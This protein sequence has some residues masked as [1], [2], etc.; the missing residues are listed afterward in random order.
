MG[1]TALSKAISAL[2]MPRKP[3]EPFPLHQKLTPAVSFGLSEPA[4]IP[5]QR[6]AHRTSCNRQ[7]KPPHA[8]LPS[9]SA[10]GHSRISLCALFRHPCLQVHVRA[11][12]ASG[13]DIATGDSQLYRY[14]NLG[15]HLPRQA[16]TKRNV[17]LHGKARRRT[18]ISETQ[19]P[20]KPRR[21][22]PERWQV[23]PDC[24]GQ[25]PPYFSATVIARKSRLSRIAFDMLTGIALR[26]SPRVPRA[27][28]VI[29]CRAKLRG[30]FL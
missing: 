15:Q 1:I 26:P 3:I 21:I 13:S 7:H 28:S 30:G 10:F 12:P 19:S 18:R 8:H 20:E 2:G 6:P 9:T 24:R 22:L 23:L 14:T 17:Q 29:S 27:T 25:A 4:P 16:P 11:E 5:L